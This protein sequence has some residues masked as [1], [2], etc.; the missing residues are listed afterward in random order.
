[1]SSRHT[2]LVTGGTGLVGRTLI[3]MLLEEGKWE[4][5]VFVRSSS[6]RSS[7]PPQCRIVVVRLVHQSSLYSVIPLS[8]FSDLS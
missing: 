6:N 4:V 8:L 7:I 3:P 5:V 1:M 2:V